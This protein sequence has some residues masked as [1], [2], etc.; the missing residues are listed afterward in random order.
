MV[1]KR[2]EKKRSFKNKSYTYHRLI[3]TARYFPIQWT[4]EEIVYELIV[5]KVAIVSIGQF[6]HQTQQHKMFPKRE[7]KKYFALNIQSQMAHDRI[8]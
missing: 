4:L 1:K 5:H 8:L 7:V 6:K 2:K 3:G